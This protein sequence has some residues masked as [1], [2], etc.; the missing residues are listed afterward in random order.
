MFPRRLSRA[1]PAAD[2]P[3]DGTAGDGTAGAAGVA[4][5]PGSWPWRR[6][7][8]LAL[9][10]AQLITMA[11]L[12][13]A[14]PIP[15]SWAVVLLAVAPA[16]LALLVAF[17]PAPAAR[18]AAPGSRGGAG[19]RDDRPGHAHGRF[20]L[21]VLTGAALRRLDS[22]TTTPTAAA[23]STI[24]AKGLASVTGGPTVRNRWR[25][26]ADCPPLQPYETAMRECVA[27]LARCLKA[28]A[29]ESDGHKRAA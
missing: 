13:G 5:A 6:A 3:P 15:V 23:S 17:A 26:G 16:P 28:S 18:L 7:A 22:T 14:D 4:A 29:G 25:A 19:D 12:E 2:A 24:T 8:L 9:I 21:P 11:A 27:S 20:F 1:V 10:A